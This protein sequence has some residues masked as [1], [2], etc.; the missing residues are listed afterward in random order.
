MHIQHV[1]VYQKENLMKIPTECK[2]KDIF[3]MILTCLKKD[4]PPEKT[5]DIVKWKFED[6]DL[7]KI[8]KFVAEV[9]DVTPKI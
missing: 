2:N 3:E 7:D 8:V 4:Y 9:Y 5:L 1:V 6:A